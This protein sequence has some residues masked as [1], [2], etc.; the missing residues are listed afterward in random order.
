MNIFQK[1]FLSINSI[2]SL[3]KFVIKII[4]KSITK[5]KFEIWANTTKKT[6]FKITAASSDLQVISEIKK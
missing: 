6:P 1:G 2:G 5:S 4:Q 3:A